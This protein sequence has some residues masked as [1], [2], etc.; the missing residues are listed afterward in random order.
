[1]NRS[2]TWCCQHFVLPIRPAQGPCATRPSGK[3]THTFPRNMWLHYTVYTLSSMR[4]SHFAKQLASFHKQRGDSFPSRWSDSKNRNIIG[5]QEHE[6]ELLWWLQKVDSSSFTVG[7]NPAKLCAQQRKITH[8]C[9]KTVIKLIKN[10]SWRPGH[11]K[12]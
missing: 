11:V 7:M 2:V 9:N 6:A 10:C 1:M 4:F 3:P 5:I 12:I 8:F